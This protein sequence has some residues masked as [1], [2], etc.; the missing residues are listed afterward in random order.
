M[1]YS[2]FTLRKVKTE[3]GISIVEGDRFLPATQPIDPSVYLQE[4]LREGLSLAIATGSEKARSELIISPILVEVRK[5][6]DRRVSLFSG[7]D[8]TVDPSRGLSGVC[9]FLMSRSSEQVM[10][11]APAIII[12]EAKKGD[13]KVG[14]GQCA[15]EMV[16]AQSF[17]A[18][19][20]VVIPTIYGSVSSGTAWR[21][22]KLD[23]QVLTLDLN[24]Y[25]V[26][27]VEVLLGMLVWMVKQG[28][29][30]D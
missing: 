13:L 26:P 25:A 22:M 8:F 15:A 2:D 30:I 24:D 28:W 10:I 17:N 18:T 1:A 7:E 5:I 29:T 4:S 23:N 27:P 6:L 3:L 9:D 21:F 11:E 14:L 20:G 16:A 19:N 12:I